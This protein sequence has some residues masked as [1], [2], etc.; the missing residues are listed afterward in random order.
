VR[1]TRA[2]RDGGAG[3]VEM[4]VVLPLL[5]VCVLAVAHMSLYYLARQAALSTAQVAVAGQRGWDSAPG[6]GAARAERFA[7]RLPGVLRDPRI[8]LECDGEPLAGA[9]DG[10]QVSATVSGT[11]HSVIPWLRHPVSQTAT[12]PVERVTP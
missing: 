8:I 12:G 7:A 1:G 2:G 5:L 3:G 11:A 4:A 10:R 9:C 6:A